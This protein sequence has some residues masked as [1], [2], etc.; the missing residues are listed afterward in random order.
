MRNFKRRGSNG[1]I[2]DD[3]WSSGFASF[4]V[5]IFAFQILYAALHAVSFHPKMKIIVLL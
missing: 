3:G 1:C 4:F 2:A 5:F